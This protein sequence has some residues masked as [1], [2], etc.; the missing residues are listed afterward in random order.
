[1]A[2][3]T[4][5]QILVWTWLV[6]AH[7]TYFRGAG[8]G[9]W[10]GSLL[11]LLVCRHTGDLMSRVWRLHCAWG[12]GNCNRPLA[13][14]ALLR[15]AARHARLLLP[16]A[17]TAPGKLHICSATHAGERCCPHRLVVRTSRCGRDNP[18]SNPGVDMV[19]G[20]SQNIFPRYGLRAMA[21]QLAA[22]VGV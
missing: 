4:Q 11:H 19:G 1:M 12:T 6:G 8:L 21:W 22:R 3:T 10:L 17:A 9:L 2:A 18:G 20:G 15:P 14:A 16:G 5:V 7:K 13:S